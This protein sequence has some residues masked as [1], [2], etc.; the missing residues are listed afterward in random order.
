[1]LSCSRAFSAGIRANRIHPPWGETCDASP[2]SSN[3][4]A[5]A[6]GSRVPDW[7]SKY[8]QML[9]KTSEA[10]WSLL[11]FHGFGQGFGQTVLHAQNNTRLTNATKRKLSSFS[12]ASASALC[13]SEAEH[14]PRLEWKK[15]KPRTPLRCN[16]AM[17][18]KVAHSSRAEAFALIR[19][20][21]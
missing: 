21:K 3:A 19:A 8:Q 5:H 20:P 2:G 10:V 6:E 9:S 4:S 14:S 12:F 15:P 11:T 16:G 13:K 7:G 1:M 18:K 17:P